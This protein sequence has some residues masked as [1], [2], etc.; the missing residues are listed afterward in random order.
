MNLQQIQENDPT[1]QETDQPAIYV[2]LTCLLK[3]NLNNQKELKTANYLRIWCNNRCKLV[4]ACNRK[5]RK[6][7]YQK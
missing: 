3:D 1:A 5:M 2:P 4:F 7:F 6:P